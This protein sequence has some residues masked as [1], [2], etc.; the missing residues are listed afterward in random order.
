MSGME[1]NGTKII[2]LPVTYNA[3]LHKKP[4]LHKKCGGC[5]KSQKEAN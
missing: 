3:A 5:T 2:G 1:I 4:L